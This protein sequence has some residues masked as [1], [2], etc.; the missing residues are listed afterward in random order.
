MIFIRYIHTF[1]HTVHTIYILTYIHTNIHTYLP[2]YI[3]YL[4]MSK[5]SI[6]LQYKQLYIHTYIFR[7]S[8]W[9]FSATCLQ[10]LQ[11]SVVEGLSRTATSD[12]QWFFVLDIKLRPQL[13]VHS[14]GISPLLS[15]NVWV[16]LSPPI[17][18][19]ETRPTA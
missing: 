13:T 3:V 14:T 2:A 19:R 17:E 11:G 18:R 9:G 15:T 8:P 12:S 16:L 1:I 10:Q 7:C 6:I 5:S 4:D